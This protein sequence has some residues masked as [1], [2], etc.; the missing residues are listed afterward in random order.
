[1]PSGGSLTDITCNHPTL[2]SFTFD[3]YGSEDSTYQLG[4]IMSDDDDT[5]ITGKGVMVDKMT[6]QRA[7]LS[8]TLAGSPGDGTIENLQAL[9]GDPVFGVWTG[10]NIN[11]T[12][13]KITGK[14]VGALTA[15]G[16]DSKIPVKV[17]GG[18]SLQII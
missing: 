16:M 4:A 5:A 17:A 9:Q 7:S 12:V 1:M 2:G 11:G 15:S 6:L 14:P 10:T 3:P 13:Y 8:F 18:G